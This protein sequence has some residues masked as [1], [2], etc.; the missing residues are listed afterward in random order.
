MVAATCP[1]RR[2]ER[3]GQKGWQR[4]ADSKGTGVG[5]EGAGPRSR[6]GRPGP[7]L[8]SAVHEWTG[9]RQDCETEV[10]AVA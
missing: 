7:R 8:G 9:S 4:G 6:D 2:G 5:E 3:E 10:P 1:G